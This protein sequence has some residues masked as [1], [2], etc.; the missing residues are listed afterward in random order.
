MSKGGSKARDMSKVR[1]IRRLLCS[2]S[3]RL[4]MEKVRK[5]LTVSRPN[6]L[7]L[8]YSEKPSSEIRWFWGQ[9]WAGEGEAN[10]PKDG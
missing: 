3:I 6:L 1:D 7:L 8:L 2:P 4:P 10:M 9:N 5:T